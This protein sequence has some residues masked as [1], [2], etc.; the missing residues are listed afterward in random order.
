M[1]N[2]NKWVID[3]L[4]IWTGI[5]VILLMI[6]N[7][8]QHVPLWIIVMYLCGGLGWL[9]YR[10]MDSSYNDKPDMLL[11]GVTVTWFLCICGYYA[12]RMLRNPL[13]Q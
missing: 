10:I 7:E 13:A 8:L 3:I 4:T 1:K 9:L 6:E 12:T 11:I 2:K 5:G